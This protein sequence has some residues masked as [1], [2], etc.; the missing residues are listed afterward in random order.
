MVEQKIN[1]MLVEAQ[2]YKDTYLK[3]KRHMD[4]KEFQSKVGTFLHRAFSNYKSFDD[5]VAEHGEKDI[6]DRDDFDEDNY[7]VAYI[8]KSLRLYFKNDRLAEDGL[9][10]RKLKKKSIKKY[11]RDERFVYCE[12]CGKLMVAKSSAAKYCDDCKKERNRI[13]MAEVRKKAKLITED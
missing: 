5:Y 1:E 2:Q 8:L 10:N 13:R 9:A 11:S 3:R 7:T 4:F 6:Y 12:Q